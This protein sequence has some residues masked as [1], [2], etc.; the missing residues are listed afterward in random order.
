VLHPIS[1]IGYV[2]VYRESDGAP[3]CVIVHDSAA[4]L[5]TGL[6]YP[7]Y[8]LVSRD[9]GEA[10][11]VCVQRALTRKPFRSALPARQHAADVTDTLLRMW[12]IN[13]LTE[14]YRARNPSC[15]APVPTPA[16]PAPTEAPAAL[17]PLLDVNRIAGILDARAE[18][19]AERSERER[20]TAE[21]LR[22]Q[23]AAELNGHGKKKPRS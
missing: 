22:E 16:A 4:D 20:K 10:D 6:S 19:S 13:E 11:S 5:L 14:W 3:C 15:S 12:R 23:K 8:V 17:P 21:W 1:V 7:D 9:H 2:P 18:K